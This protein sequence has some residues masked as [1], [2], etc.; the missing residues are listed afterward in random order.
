MYLIVQAPFSTQVLKWLRGAVFTPAGLDLCALQNINLG[1][2]SSLMPSTEDNKG[3]PKIKEQKG[4]L[5]FQPMLVLTSVEF[6]I[7]ILDFKK[8]QD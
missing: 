6:I 4:Y 2:Y 7:G 5:C 3:F 1:G 8:Q